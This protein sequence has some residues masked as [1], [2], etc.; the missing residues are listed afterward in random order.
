MKRGNIISFD[1]TLNFGHVL[2]VVSI[3]GCSF[4]AWYDVK[5]TIAKQQMQIDEN[6]TKIE[7]YNEEA[8]NRDKVTQQTFLD[9]QKEQR[10]E[11]AKLRDD[12]NNWFMKLD[13]K[14]DRKADKK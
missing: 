13:D 9:N 10:Q 2:T 6:S 1:S 4:G 5:S 12:M 3:I 14:L 8:I 7:R 11:M